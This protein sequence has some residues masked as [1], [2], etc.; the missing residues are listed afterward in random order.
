MR[1]SETSGDI[2][3]LTQ[4]YTPEPTFKGD[5]FAR[6]LN[7]AG[8][9]VE[10]VTGFPNYPGGRVYDGYRMRGIAKGLE[11][12]LEVVRLAT[13]PSHDRSAIRR[14]LSYLS[15]AATSFLYL[16]FRRRPQ[17]I[18]VYYPSL[19]AGLAAIAVKWLRRVPVVVDIQDM[20]PDSLGAAGMM[21][22]R[23][24]IAIVEWF[25][26]ILYR[27]VDH[28]VVLSPGFRDTLIK[29]GVPAEKITV[30]YNWADEIERHGAEPETPPASSLFDPQH[31]F[32]LLFAGNM[33][34]MQ[35]LDSVLDAAKLV[36]QQRSDIGCYF[37]GGGV[38]VD[39]LKARVA[40]EGIDNVRF[41]PRVPLSEV[42]DILR[43]AGAL[44]VHLARDPLFDIT[45]PS[46]TQAYLYA[47][48]PIVMAV[49][50]NAADLVREAEGGIVIQPE[51]PQAL[52]E[53]IRQLAD[54]GIEGRNAMGARARAFY[55]RRL[56]FRHGL[57][58]TIGIIERFR[59]RAR[60]EMRSST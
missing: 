3:Y 19:T 13:Y 51:D 32:T 4:L 50:G 57:D 28:I 23:R 53:A 60:G 10:V 27:H 16:L 20:W 9:A 14:I 46:K 15:F 56:T 1:S 30:I 34:A 29:R 52:A 6:G 22:N 35:R 8:Y 7:E 41:L 58:A 2:V 33:G 24:L 5:R 39:R 42:Q 25:C 59:H 21:Q 37:M 12:G 55:D 49:E 48:R 31:R 47:G 26:Q 43:Q 54:I 44:L 18:Y 17:L 11:L 36:A 40:D 38:D 45:V